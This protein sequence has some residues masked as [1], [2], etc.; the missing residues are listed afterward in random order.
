MNELAWLVGHRFQ[1]LTRREFDWVLVFD[2]DA[3]LVVECL[4]RLVEDSRIRFTSQDDGHQFGVPAPVDAATEVNRRLAGAAVEAVE[5]R[6]GILDLEL[7]FSTEHD[8]Q[9]IPDS[10]GYEAW[11][12]S[13]GSRQFIAVGGGTL[14]ILGG[15]PA[16][17]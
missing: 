4:W 11:N 3:S 15:D 9:V 1:S 8:F 7:R 13:I 16:N 2:K 14:A 17:G 12:L 10:S 6:K 5:L